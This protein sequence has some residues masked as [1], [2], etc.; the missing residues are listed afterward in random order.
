MS[1]ER[2]VALI[3]MDCFY[4]QVH[5][6]QEP[7]YRGK[8]AVVVQYQ[9]SREPQFNQNQ[10]AENMGKRQHGGDGIIAVSYEARAL[11][12]KRGEHRFLH[13]GMGRTTKIHCTFLTQISNPIKS[14]EAVPD[15]SCLSSGRKTW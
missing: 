1:E 13:Q 15:H 2:I 4:V 9:K 5:L 3:D 12:V 8:P 10:N 7:E 6:E 11:G 14:T